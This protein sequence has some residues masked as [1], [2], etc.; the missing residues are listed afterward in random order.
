M[1]WRWRLLLAAMA[2]LL[3]AVSI[4]LVL[5]QLGPIRYV[6]PNQPKRE[7]GLGASARPGVPVGQTFVSRHAGLAGIE[8]FLI[9]EFSTSLDM[10]LHLREG[11]QSSTD[12]A[13]ASLQLPP[14]SSPGFYRFSFPPLKDSHGGY[15][16]AFIEVPQDEQGVVPQ[17]IPVA[18]AGGDAYLDGAAHLA[19]EPLEA[20]VSFHLVYAPGY[21]VSDLLKAVPSGVGLLAAAALLLGVPGWAL[22]VWLWPGRRLTWMETLALAPG[23]GLALYPLL[24]LWT[25]LVGLHLSAL[26]AWLPVTAG[27]FALIWRFRNW[28]PQDGWASLRGWARS[29][30]IWP[31]LA[32]LGLLALAFGVRFVAV[33]TL[34]T[35]MWA[36]SYHHTMIAQLLVDNEGLFDSWAPYAELERL[37]Y[38]FGFHSTVAAFHWLTRLP[39]IEA[40][41][42]MG[43][44]VN[45]LAVLALYPLAKRVTGTRWGGVWAVLLAGLLS[46]MPMYYVNWGRFTQ[47]AGQVILPAAVWLTWEMVE[48]PQR[49]LSVIAASA[50]VAGGLAL[51]HYRVLI[52]YGGFVVALALINL[53]KGAWRETVVR[54]ACTALG[55]SILCLPW[56]FRVLE[57]NIAL[58]LWEQLTTASQNVSDFVREYN[59][60]SNLDFYLA[61]V[62][63]LTVLLGLGVGLWRRRRGVL[64]VGL[65]WFLLLVATNP[66]W[67]SLPGTGVISNFALFIAAY[68]PASLLSA[69]L[70]VE[71][72]GPA[73]HR[74]RVS[75]LAFLVVLLLGLWGMRERMGDSNPAYHALVT[76]PDRQAASWIRDN[77]PED[78]RFLVNSCSAYG[79][80]SIIGS[81]GGWWLPLLADRQNTVPPMPYTGEVRADS[82]YHQQVHELAR[83]MPQHDPD[84]PSVRSR[85]LQQGVTHVYLGQRQ[86]SVACTEDEAIDPERLADS[87]AFALLY[88]QDRVW[89]FALRP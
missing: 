4:F 32:L 27:L 68:I 10:T 52:F 56:A 57:G 30:A 58:I 15:Y 73:A 53:R 65:W 54:L 71:L 67:L 43:Q 12:L 2:V 86:G 48:T 38:H 50:V 49:R 6:V 79:G 45:G 59:A 3:L 23:I 62:W 66:A 46:P 37:S 7:T 29:D 41:I 26:Y 39:V 72:I 89:V 22:L 88:N 17:E 78:A 75:T 24:F 20:Q 13:T 18:L 60:L 40:T 35:A 55:A 51:T 25:D 64:L 87:D 14:G 76:R 44:V 21:V 84:D 34:E 63:W 33:R 81:D 47:L 82:E 74:P 36:D 16:Y 42:W 70:V 80:N 28:R 1:S 61:P 19:H 9:P 85:L 77:T 69:T 31:D 8:L 11:P 83:Q 5:G